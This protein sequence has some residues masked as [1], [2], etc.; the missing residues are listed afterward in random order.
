M[1][2]RYLSIIAIAVC[3]TVCCSH[4]GRTV[5]ISEPQDYL[6]ITDTVKVIPK[7]CDVPFLMP[8]R[9]L[10]TD[11]HLVIANRNTGKAFI[12]YNLP[13]N[14]DGFEAVHFGRGPEE[15]IDPDFM[16]MTAK[17]GMVM[18]ADADDYMKSFS[19]GNGKVGLYEKQRMFIESLQNG[20]MMVRN[21][22][23][24]YNI[25]N[26]DTQPY[27][28]SISRPDGSQGFISE[29]PHWDDSIEESS[30]QGALIY[31]NCHVAQPHGDRIA[32]FYTRF[33]KVR[34]VDIHGRLLS[35]TAINYPNSSERIHDQPDG[36]GGYYQTYGMVVAS[37]DRIVAQAINAMR[38]APPEGCSEF[39]VWDWDGNLLKRI[40]IK[41]PINNFAVDFVSGH[42]Y[43]ICAGNEDTVF[44]ADIKEML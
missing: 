3:F 23:L 15:L 5:I 40:M 39:Q 21:R 17:D 31:T 16:S 2:L 6:L 9:V 22:F 7:H 27:E 28:F 29:S 33:R 42:L 19:I 14:G 37:D 26:R 44:F 32:E 38:L 36:S 10:V 30:I 20:V 12:I 8:M 41:E 24:N 34:I 18:V 11:N 43:G 4:I 35:E 25:N 13:L 1:R